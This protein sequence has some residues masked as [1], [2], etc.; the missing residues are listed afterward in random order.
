M[1]KNILFAIF[2][3]SSQLVSAQTGNY[4]IYNLSTE[5][6]LPTNDLQVVYQDSYGFLW[7][8]SYDGLSRWDGYSFKTYHHQ[9]DN[10]KSLDHNIVYSIFED[11]KKN[12]WVGTIEGLNLYDRVH[13]NFVGC[14]IQ[15]KG[16]KIPVN[17]IL[18]DSKHRLWLGTSVGLCHYDHDTQKSNWFATEANDDVIFCLTRDAHDNIWTGTFNGGV[19][20]FSPSTEQFITFHAASGDSKTLSSNKIK[21]LMTDHDNNIWVGTA[22]QGITVLNSDGIA[23]HHYNNFS[24]NSVNCLYEDKNKTIWIGAVREPLYYIDQKSGQPVPLKHASQNNAQYPFFS[25]SS[26]RQDSFGNI[27]FATTGNGLFYTNVNKNIFKDYLQDPSLLKGL[28]TNVV[29]TFHEDDHGNVW[30]GTD[31]GGLI[32]FQ[33]EKN[34]F[35][36]YTSKSN[37]LTSDAINDIKSD[38]HG[39]L[40]ITTWSGGVMQ[41]DPVSAKITR[42]LNDPANNNSLIENDAKAILPDDTIVWIGTHGEGLTAYDLKRKEFIHHKNNRHFPFQ[43]NDPAWINH[44]F[45]DSKQR[46]WISTYSGVFV[47]DGK[48]LDHYQHTRDTASISNNSVN[49]VAEDRGGR[50]WVICESGDLDLFNEQ[51]KNFTHYSR[52]FTLPQTMKGLVIDDRGKLWISSNEGIVSFDPER[53]KVKKYDASEGLQGNSFFH[54]A[55]LKRKN[56][57]LYFGGQHGFTVF[58]PDSLKP[59]HIP[60]YFYFND[61]YVYNQVQQEGDEGSP[62]EHVLSFTNNLTLKPKQS[63]FSIDFA[64]INLYSPSKTQYAYKLEGL[65]NE[66]IYLNNERKVSFTNLDPGNYTLTIKYTNVDGEWQIAPNALHIT[67]LPPWWKTWWFKSLLVAVVIGGIVGVFYLRVASIRNRNKLLKEEVQK[68]TQELSEANTFLTERNDEIR[69]QKEK[70]EQSNN[71]VVRQ[72]NKILEQQQHIVAQNLVLERS[73]KELEKLNQTKD[74]FFSILAHDLK[75]PIAALTGISDYLKNNFTRLEKKDAQE[76]LGSIHKSASSVYDLLIN[77][78]SWSRSQSQ[79]IVSAPSDI[80]V[81]ELVQKNAALL[82]QQFANKHI[83]FH[84]EFNTAQNAF[85]DYHMIDTV[86]RNL[87][88]NSIKF[89]NYNGTVTVRTADTDHAITICI[90][91][92]GVGMLKDQLEKLFSIDKNNVSVGTAG[93]RGTGLGLVVTKEFIAINK[94]DIQVESETGKGTSFYITLP[95]STSTSKRSQQ[96]ASAADVGAPEAM[97]LDFWEAFPTEKLIKIK[98]RKILIVDDNK[99]LRTYLKLLLSGTFEIFEAEDGAEGLKLALEIQ[100]T[101]IISDLIMP[102]MDGFQFC[103]NIKSST[104]TSHIPVIMLTSQAQDKSQLSGYEAGADVYLTKPVEKELLIQVI[105]NFIQN[106][107]RIRERMRESVLAKNTLYPEDATLNKLDEEFLNNLVTFVETNISDPAIDARSICENLGMSRTILYAKVKTLTGQ[108]VHE[109][110]KSI[111]LKK[112]LR[113][114]LDGKLTI[115]QIAMEVGFNSHSYFDKCFVKYYG[116]GPKEYVNKKRKNVSTAG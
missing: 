45:K 112:S 100:P 108:S 79:N 20:K 37:Q 66:W 113:F 96:R 77:L 91:D 104:T 27:W 90:S 57:Q 82:Q 7:L 68:R 25:I 54:K 21:S 19:K 71:E 42:Y 83:T 65:H 8:A 56:G 10:P 58:H 28:K 38:K 11:S 70:L 41:F 89:T 97:S 85:A 99:E 2:L 16:D 60:A 87:M 15:H 69:H 75:N 64:S 101:A 114:L 63:F 22:D 18:E 30:I 84:T 1:M 62:L 105:L 49:M 9:E 52:K 34:V 33:P 6:G 67:I 115:S 95:R 23:I 5:N 81:N 51:Q 61:L 35:T 31:R 72:S 13:D 4:N 48:K 39:N 53:S 44:L 47:F 36:L 76:H 74:H 111:R 78:L 102:V 98:G 106:Q 80:N 86:I 29:T 94:G 109:F 40:W 88:S 50:I 43:L 24:Q 116:I 55:V 59:V 107:E 92:T 3:V 12:L 110:I 26:I 73:V 93:E 46:L 32:K 14:T 17:A 103:K